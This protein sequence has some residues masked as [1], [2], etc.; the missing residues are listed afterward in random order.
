MKFDKIIVLCIVLLTLMTISCVVA[1]ENSTLN[2]NS[3]INENIINTIDDNGKTIQ[4][5]DES[6]ATNDSSANQTNED[7]KEDYNI[8]N[9]SYANHQD[10]IKFRFNTK[11]LLFGSFF[12]VQIFLESS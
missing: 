10:L 9:D 6:N 11:K 1:C 4:T 7:L 8:E 5:D 3:S 12:C 2:D